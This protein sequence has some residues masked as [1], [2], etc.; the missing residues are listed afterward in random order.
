MRVTG[1]IKQVRLN[2][3]KRKNILIPKLLAKWTK[4]CCSQN[5]CWQTVL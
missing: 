4:S 3:S 2:L 1:Q 5:W